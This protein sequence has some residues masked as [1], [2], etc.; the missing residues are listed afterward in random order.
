MFFVDAS[1]FEKVLWKNSIGLKSEQLIHQSC[2][3]PWLIYQERFA[4]LIYA[5]GFWYLNSLLQTERKWCGHLPSTTRF[6]YCFGDKREAQL[7][8]TVFKT[9]YFGIVL[10][11]SAE[12]RRDEWCSHLPFKTRFMLMM[13][14]WLAQLAIFVNL[15]NGSRYFEEI[16]DLIYP[17]GIL[18]FGFAT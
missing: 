3:R 6:W 10:V 7:A 9:R 13:R 18:V 11:R 5:C 17:Y 1:S 15:R 16:R 2:P 4:I 12:A 14:D 8:H